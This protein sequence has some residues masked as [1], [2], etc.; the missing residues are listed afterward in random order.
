[1]EDW[2]NR[3]QY[4]IN[5]GLAAHG[6]DADAMVMD[7]D[8]AQDL[9]FD[10]VIYDR[11]DASFY[12]AGDGF[13]DSFDALIKWLNSVEIMDT[14][15]SPFAEVA[16]SD[17]GDWRECRAGETSAIDKIAGMIARG[18]VGMLDGDNDA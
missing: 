17:V 7:T 13:A 18:V 11:D 6:L 2:P 8:G 12:V 1:M 15:Q 10:V 16:L 4:G 3:L 9:M 14:R 5:A